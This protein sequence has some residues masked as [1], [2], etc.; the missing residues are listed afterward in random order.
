MF[1]ISLLMQAF[2]WC[3]KITVSNGAISKQML[4]F[5]QLSQLGFINNLTFF[6]N[7]NN[8]TFHK[9]LKIITRVLSYKQVP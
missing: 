5:F 7:Y 4:N 3:Q 1:L 2:K 8:L 6:N 9:N